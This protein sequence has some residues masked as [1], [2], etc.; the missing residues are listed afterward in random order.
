MDLTITNGSASRLRD[1]SD[2][3]VTGRERESVFI[4]RGPNQKWRSFAQKTCYFPTFNSPFFIILICVIYRQ[5]NDRWRRPLNKSKYGHV[6]MQTS[7]HD[8][9]SEHDAKCIYNALILLILYARFLYATIFMAVIG[10]EEKSKQ[11]FFSKMAK[12][13]LIKKNEFNFYIDVSVSSLH[14]LSRH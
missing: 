3:C 10:R 5:K 7:R 8:L 11:F 9:E 4:I 13:I 6:C 12:P 2:N 14:F 1:R